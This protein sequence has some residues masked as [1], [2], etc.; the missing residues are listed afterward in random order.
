MKHFLAACVALLLSVVAFQASAADT[1]PAVDPAI[2][3][4]IVARM[5]A[6]R[7]DLSYEV[8]KPSPI[9]G[10]YE[11]QVAGGPVLYVREGGE[12]FF[13]G[14]LYQARPGMFVNLREQ[15]LVGKRKQAL[16]EIPV[17]DLI[18]YSP[19]GKPKAVLNVFTDIDCG[20]CRKLH[21]AVPDLNALGIEVRYLAF[22]RAG[23]GSGSYRKAVTAW[24][25]D[26]RQEALTRL[27]NG[28]DVPEKLCEN[29]PVAAQFELGQELEVNGT[30]ASI[31]SDGTLIPGFRSVADIASILGV[32]T[33]SPAR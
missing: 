27:K 29:N 32:D 12:Y 25:S 6:A 23:L 3:K 28:E 24:C 31:L 22:P 16:A 5:Q 26:N 4:A 20:Y 15:D 8:L 13:D 10:F 7:P 33:T 9:P 21:Q 1:A 19:V 11:V 30:P 14:A 17:S 18:V 2:A